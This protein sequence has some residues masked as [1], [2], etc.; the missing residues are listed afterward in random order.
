MAKSVYEEA[1]DIDNGNQHKSCD[2]NGALCY[3]IP[4]IYRFLISA[5]NEPGGGLKLIVARQLSKGRNI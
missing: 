2:K 3:N 4:D 1:T 5:G